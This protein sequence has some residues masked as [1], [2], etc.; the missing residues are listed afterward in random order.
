MRVP[1]ACEVCQLSRRTPPPHSPMASFVVATPARKLSK[2]YTSHSQH[3]TLQ[4]D[5]R[6]KAH[7][8][9]HRGTVRAHATH[10]VPIPSCARR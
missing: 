6:G 3:C 1:L 8:R 5:P 7:S 9:R 10:R 4:T 2:R